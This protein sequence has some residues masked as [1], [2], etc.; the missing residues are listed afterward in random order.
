MKK[1]II[2][3]L[4]LLTTMFTKAQDTILYVFDPMCGWCY[5]FSDVIKK[6][7]MIIP[8]RPILK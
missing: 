5:G 8:H 6:S 2:F 3:I 4:L 7:Q 1:G